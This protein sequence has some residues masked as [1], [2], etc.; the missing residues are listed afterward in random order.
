[1]PHFSSWSWPQEYIGPLDE[2]LAKI[3]NREEF[4]HWENKLDIAGW[5]GTAWFNPEWSP[6]LRPRLLEIT[7]KKEWADVETWG[8]GHIGLDNTVRIEEFCRYKYI[9][10]AEVGPPR[11][12]S[13]QCYA[14]HSTLPAT[15]RKC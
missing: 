14:V 6:G 15:N 2:A 4:M 13:S 3:E 10:Y 11:F 12:P 1:M 5:R 9:I 8:Q 7:D